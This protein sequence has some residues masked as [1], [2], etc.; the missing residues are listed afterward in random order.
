MIATPSAEP[1]CRVV[2]ATAGGDAGL[3]ARHPGD[4][5]VGD[6][7]VHPAEAGAEQGVAE[8]EAQVARF[9]RRDRRDEPG[10]EHRGAADDQ[11]RP[12]PAVADQS[13]RQRREDHHQRRHRQQRDAGV[14]RRVAAHVLQVERVEEEEAAERDEGADRDDRGAAERRRAEEA[15]VD[16]RLGVARLPEDEA[17]ARGERAGEAGE[18]QVRA[19]AVVRRLDDP[20]DEQP[21]G[22]RSSA[23]GRPGRAGA[24][25]APSIR[26]RTC[27]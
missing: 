4:G 16:Q 25:A 2:E 5:G 6:R 19:P 12:R 21:Q 24:G 10:G 14:E 11:R 17:A 26:G 22:Q 23:P 13:S 20:E 1:S 3:L 8:E 9:A 7:R 27:G 15:Q 18:D